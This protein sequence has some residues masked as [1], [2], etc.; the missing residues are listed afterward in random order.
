M[1][2]NYSA[3][4][5]AS[6]LNKKIVA[7]AIKLIRLCNAASFIKPMG[8]VRLASGGGCDWRKVATAAAGV[9]FV[10]L[11]L[12]LALTSEDG[13]NEVDAAGELRNE[14]QRDTSLACE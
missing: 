4:F 14:D 7:V 2:Q 8:S 9:A 10:L 3:R 12:H 1:T 5:S 13:N 11:F 6:I